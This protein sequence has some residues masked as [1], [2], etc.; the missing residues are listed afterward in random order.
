MRETVSAC[1]LEVA[2]A[3]ALPLHWFTFL[4]Q[5]IMMNDIFIPAGTLWKQFGPL[6]MSIPPRAYMLALKITAGRLKSMFEIIARAYEDKKQE[7][8]PTMP[9][10]V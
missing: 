5:V 4:T 7:E 3:H 6:H 1:L 2:R 9:A 8:P 10:T